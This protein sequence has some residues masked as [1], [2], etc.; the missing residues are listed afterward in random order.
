[1]NIQISFKMQIPK[2][3]SFISVLLSFVPQS[4]FS[5]E[6]WNVLWL[7][8][9]D[10]DPVLSCYGTKGINT[11]N[12]DRLANE[13]IRYSHAYATVAVSAASRSSIITGMYPAS[14]GTI[15][16]RTGP[17]GSF[18]EP[19]KE[20]YKTRTGITDQLGREIPEYS[21]VL[22]IGVKCFSE[23]MR[24]NGFY[25]TNR[26]KTDYQFNCPITAWDEIGT[27]NSTYASNNIPAGMPFFSVINYFVTHESRIW[28]NKDHPMLVNTDSIYIPLYYPNIPVVRK[29]VGRKYSN[30]EELDK[31]IGERL[32]DLEKRGLMDKTIIIFFSDH[33]GPLLHQKRAIGNSGM[34]VPLIVRFPD[35]R[36][37]GTVCNDIV[38]LMDLGPTTMS[39]AGI[40]PPSYMQGKAFLGKYKS[41][42]PKKYHF[43]S[44]DRFDESRD[45]CRSVLDGRF[46]YVKNFRPE[47]P[48][49][50]RNKYREQIEMTKTLLKMNENAEL[51]G[52]AAYIFMK[53]K[54]VEELY[55]LQTDPDEVHNLA[56]LPQYD[57]I[58]KELRT[59]LAEWQKD[60]DDKG[61]IP[62]LDLIKSMWPNLI[63]PVTSDVDFKVD[64]QKRI[65]LTC[66]TPGASIAYQTGDNIG[67]QFWKLYYKPLDVNK[68]EKIIARA[69]R[70]GYKTSET[71]SYSSVDSSYVLK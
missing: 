57:K 18:R 32:A 23:Y 38:S 51:R 44:A 31:Q 20:T 19:E 30:I 71:K 64:K 9:E 62:E 7:S 60:I 29:D 47:L 4:G 24:M 66:N 2:S 33:G 58:L 35:K 63:Q 5:Q 53:T 52:D 65:V 11:P 68:N 36:M 25:C 3:L 37:A 13:G 10:I 48:M 8:C 1:M 12:I 16:H 26:D 46:V 40:Q 59:A 21:A 42:S 70:I 54:P 55:D 39:L 14:I 56:G 17:H 67:S 49:T 28:A 41:K 22:P 61:F 6:K 69:V 50:Y 27:E 15:H 43:G 45:M 34:Q